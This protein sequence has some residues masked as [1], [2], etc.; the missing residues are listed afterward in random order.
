MI[1]VSKVLT[2]KDNDIY[3]FLE[4]FIQS[5]LNKYDEYRNYTC[6]G[7]CLL[8]CKHLPCAWKSLLITNDFHAIVLIDESFW[9]DM[10]V[11][12]II[13]S[14]F[15]EYEKLSNF[16]LKRYDNQYPNRFV[17]RHIFQITK[18]ETIKVKS[19]NL[20]DILKKV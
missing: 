10:F 12:I 18:V 15:S 14:D 11:G 9:V 6:E 8:L 17:D 7:A 2:E 19:F 16:S 20:K 1:E 3:S 4:W 13:N 5:E